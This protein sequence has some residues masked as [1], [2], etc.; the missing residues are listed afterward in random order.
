MRIFTVRLKT[1]GHGMIK[2][3]GQSQSCMVST[4]PIIFKRTRISSACGSKTAVCKEVENGK[5]GLRFVLIVA[6]SVNG[7]TA[8]YMYSAVFD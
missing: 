5:E 3:V 6:S 7:W 4:L 8:S 2:H 1:I